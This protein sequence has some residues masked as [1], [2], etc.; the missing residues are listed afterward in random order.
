MYENERLKKEQRHLDDK[1]RRKELD[2]D[3]VRIIGRQQVGLA[4]RLARP[5]ASEGGATH[6]ILAPTAS[7]RLASSLWFA[8]EN[9]C[10]ISSLV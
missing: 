3:A 7:F 4:S 2:A 8:V 10:L 9:L 5:F 1:R 6:R